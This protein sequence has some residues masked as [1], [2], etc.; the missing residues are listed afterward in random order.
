MTPW[1]KAK[2]WQEENDPST[3]FWELLGEHLSCGVVHSTR[4]LFMLAGEV[5]WNKEDQRFEQGDPNCWFIRLAAAA[6]CANPVW[7][8]MRCLPHPHQY[9][10]WI[11]RGQSWPR[12]YEWEKIENKVKEH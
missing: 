1:Q 11:R 9:C 10:A 2:Q 12:V 6:G 7:D 8:Y 5:R 3:N 4:N